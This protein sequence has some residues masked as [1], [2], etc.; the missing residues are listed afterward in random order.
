[1]KNKK[2]KTIDGNLGH[3]SKFSHRF[4]FVKLS[5]VDPESISI[6]K[7]EEKV[8]QKMNQDICEITE[9]ITKNG[10]YNN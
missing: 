9:M 3:V 5:S 1:M 10:V 2:T 6:I 8:I 4:Y 7:K